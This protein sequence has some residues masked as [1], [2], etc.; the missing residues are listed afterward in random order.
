MWKIL[1]SRAYSHVIYFFKRFELFEQNNYLLKFIFRFL[2][3]VECLATTSMIS[4]LIRFC[5]VLDI[6]SGHYPARTI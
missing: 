1:I 5:M 4:T 2:L 6:F 3:V